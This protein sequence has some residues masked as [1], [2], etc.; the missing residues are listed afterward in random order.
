MMK[1]IV[2]C[3]AVFATAPLLAAANSGHMKL[4]AEG[5]VTATITGLR[6][7]DGQILACLTRRPDVFPKCVLDPQAQTLTVSASKP[8]QLDF[9]DVPAGTYAIAIIHDENANGKLDKRLMIPREGFGFSQ[10]APVRFGP[11]SFRQASFPVAAGE[12]HLTI[13]MRYML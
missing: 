13:R 4:P 2:S 9:G 7:R 1:R 6:S 8:V 10:D 3:V 12:Q 11:P 5:D